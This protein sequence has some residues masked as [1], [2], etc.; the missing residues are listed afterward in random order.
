LG[1]DR[2]IQFCLQQSIYPFVPE[3]ANGMIKIDAETG[4][5]I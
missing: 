2:D 3:V 4:N 5:N 1:I